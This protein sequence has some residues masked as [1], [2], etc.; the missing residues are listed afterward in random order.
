MKCTIQV[1]LAMGAGYLLGRRHKTRLPPEVSKITDTIRSELLELGKTAAQAAVNSQ[2]DALTSKLHER[3][4]AMR[5][6]MSERTEAAGRAGRRPD[7]DRYGQE[8]EPSE[9]EEPSDEEEPY[10]EEPYEEEE[11]EEPEPEPA[12]ARRRRR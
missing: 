5:D 12:A 3:T 9:E 8:E 4:E 7:E 6:R 10:E 2:L 1:G 11:T